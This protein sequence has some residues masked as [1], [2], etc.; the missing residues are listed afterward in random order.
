MER[1]LLRTKIT[2][3]TVLILRFGLIVVGRRHDDRSAQP[4]LLNQVDAQ[5]QA[6]MHEPTSLGPDANERGSTTTTSLRLR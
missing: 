1:D 4:T 5:L 3:V 2:G 6:A